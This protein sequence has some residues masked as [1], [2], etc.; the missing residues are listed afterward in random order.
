MRLA[1]KSGFYAGGLKAALMTVTR[2]RLVRLPHPDRGRRARAEDAAPPNPTDAA[3]PDGRLTFTKLDGVFRSGNNTRDDAPSHLSR[4]ATFPRG[5]ATLR[6]P[7]PR[8]SLRAA[9]RQARGERLEL[10][11]LQGGGRPRPP[12]ETARGRSGHEVQE[13]VTA[14][15]C[16][17]T[18]ASARRGR[19]RAGRLPRPTRL[20]P[21]P[22]SSTFEM[23]TAR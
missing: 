21:L 22:R 19:L 3:K 15:A 12:L 7:V 6:R 4:Q 1:F 18:V 17:Y 20:R 9:E 23:Q 2:R 10:R 16:V 14:R 11:R 13:D 8:G 5:P